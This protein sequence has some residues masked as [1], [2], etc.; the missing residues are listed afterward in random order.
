[1]IC[2]SGYKNSAVLLSLAID[3]CGLQDQTEDKNLSDAN[4]EAQI[5]RAWGQFLEYEAARCGATHTVQDVIQSLTSK[6]ECQSGT[7]G[8]ISLT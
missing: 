3:W 6:S 1:M 2:D 7:T 4:Q 8:Q 5:A